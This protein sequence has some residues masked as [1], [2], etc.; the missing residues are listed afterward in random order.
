M[1]RSEGNLGALRVL[2]GAAVRGHEPP[3]GVTGMDHTPRL[4]QM[5]A[6]EQIAALAKAAGLGVVIVSDGTYSGTHFLVRGVEVRMLRSFGFLASPL[7]VRAHG[8]IFEGVGVSTDEGVPLLSRDSSLQVRGVDLLADVKG[9]AGAP[10]GQAAPTQN[11]AAPGT[12]DPSRPHSWR[13]HW[14]VTQTEPVSAIGGAVPSGE[15]RDDLGSGAEAC[16]H[17]RAKDGQC[18]DCGRV[19]ASDRRWHRPEEVIGS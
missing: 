1:R 12:G 5:A 9:E 11:A 16:S 17:E 8:T 3:G 6:V 14:G 10:S 15:P 19:F 13:N 7:G 4:V 2:Q 18:P